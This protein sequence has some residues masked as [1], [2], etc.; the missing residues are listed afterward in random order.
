MRRLTKAQKAKNKAMYKYI[1]KI[2]SKTDRSVSYKEF[3]KIVIDWTRSGKY[4]NV[5]EGAR[6]Y[7]HSTQY[8][9]ADR[10]GKE[11]ILAGLKED[12]RETYDK[13]RR[14]IGPM[15]KGD[16]LI[17]QLTWDDQ[18]QGY[19][20]KGSDGNT[21]LIDLSNSPKQAELIQL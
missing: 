6:K 21:Y 15:K 17:D 1:R 8:V 18:K 9:D 2:W 11:N 14:R 13:L 12:F 7:A 16:H 19:T 3:K 10:R 20:F 4:K 5:R